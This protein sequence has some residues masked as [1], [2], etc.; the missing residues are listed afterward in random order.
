MPA[1]A[2]GPRFEL[3]FPLSEV[4]CWARRYSYSGTGEEAALIRLKPRIRK[5]RRLTKDQLIKIC[6]WKAARSAGNAHVND[7]AFVE[8]ITRLSFSTSNERARIELLILLDGVGWPTASVILHFFHKGRYPI[9][10]YRALWSVGAKSPVKYTFD[11]WWRY[12]LYCRRMAKKAG[13]RMRT[14][15]KAL[16]QYSNEH[17]R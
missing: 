4:R 11:F 14:L 10:D 2:K 12:T 1:K 17:Q 9:L 8:H 13:V 5:A 3:R 16:W 7:P 15:D 6:H